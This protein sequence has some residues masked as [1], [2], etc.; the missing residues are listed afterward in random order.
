LAD[1]TQNV[2]VTAD[3]RD[4][5]RSIAQLSKKLGE[6]QNLTS[7]TGKS[8][9]TRN[10][11]EA[12]VP[13]RAL[14]ALERG[15]QT[16]ANRA[17]TTE[18]AFARL[19]EGVGTLEVTSQAV[20]GLNEVLKD[21]ASYTAQVAQSASGATRHIDQFTSS[22]SQLENILG[23][24]NNGLV[25]LGHSITRVVVPGFAVLDDAAQASAK[26]VNAAQ[27][28]VQQLVDSTEGI[29]TFVD[30][31]FTIS[32]ATG[33]ATAGI[34]ALAAVVEGQ[35]SN[36]LYDIDRSASGALG[37][38]ADDAAA[39]VSE[40][41]RLIG[42]GQGTVSQ[43]ENL[44]RLGKERQA[45]YKADSD[46]GRK[47]VN[48]IYRAQ[49]L[50]NEEL[51]RQNDLLRAAKGLQPQNVRDYEVG[52]RR[53][54]LQSRDFKETQ[55]AKQLEEEAALQANL[56]KI[57]G[58]E[59]SLLEEKLGVQRRI[60]NEVTLQAQKARDGK[61]DGS[62]RPIRPYRT[63]EG[64]RAMGFPIALPEIAQ[65]RK[66]AALKKERA[67]ATDSLAL[68]KSNSLLAS[69]V[70][71]LR[72]QLEI[73]KALGPAYEPF[74]NGLKKANDRQSLLFRAR[75][76]RATRTNLGDENVNRASAVDAI[77]NKTNRSVIAQNKLYDIGAAIKR[78]DFETAK[79]L[80]AE[81]DLL[82]KKEQNYNGVVQRRLAFRRKEKAEA[83]ELAVAQTKEKN[84]KAEDAEKQGRKRLEGVAIGGA[85]PLLFG[86]GAGAVLGGALGGLNTNNPIFSVVT[87]A[88]GTMADQF[89]AAAADMGNA[90]RDPI[91]NFQKIAD[92][93]LLANKQ[94]E[95]YVQRLIEVG[96]VTEASS[97]VQ[98]EII[99]KIGVSGTNS[100]QNAGAAAIRL[101]KVW[102]ELNLQLQAAVSG[103]LAALLSWV[104]QLVAVGNSFRRDQA[105][106]KDVSKGLN[107]KDRAEFEKTLARINGNTQKIGSGV[108]WEMAADQRKAVIAEYA[109]RANPQSVTGNS[110]DPKT[111]EDA[112]KAAQEQ[113]DLI[114]SAY[115]EAFD[116]QRRGID[117][118]REITDYRRKVE[119]D[120]FAKQQEAKRLEIDNAR[121]AA[122]IAIEQTDLAL[123]KQFSG[124]EGLTA[125]LLGGVQTYITAR[126]TGEADLE[127]KQRQLQVNLADISKATA[128]YAYE[129]ANRRTQLERSIEDYK[130]S[131]ADYQLKIARQIQEQTVVPEG[132]V[133]GGGGGANAPVGNLGNF[134]AL[135]Q[136]IGRQ[137]SYGGNYGAFNRGGSDGGHTAHDSGKDPNLVNMTIAEIQRRQLAPNVPANQQLHAVGKYQIIGDTLRGLLKG[138]YGATGISSSDKF[139]PEVQERLG[140]ALARNRMV[141]GNV[142]ASMRGLRQEW[143]GL[144][145][146]DSGKL[147]AAITQFQKATGTQ[148]GTAARSITAPTFRAPSADTSGFAAA[149]NSITKAKED[150]LK[151]D[152]EQTKLK[153][154]AA[155]FNIQELARGQSQV[156]QSQQ[157]LK[158]EKDKLGI[159]TTVGAMSENQLAQL[160]LRAE[161]ESKIDTI[162]NSQKNTLL[163][164]NAA[165]TSG[166]ITQA[167]AND[168]IKGINTG[169]E[170]RLETTRQQIVLEQ[171]L[172]KVQQAQQLA[173]EAQKMQT[174]LATAG[175]GIRAGFTGG[176]ASKY[177]DVIGKTGN[178][179]LANQFA[180]AQGVLDQLQTAQADASALG[181]SIA[182][183][184]K[185]AIK[186]SVTGGDIG[187]AFSSM[188][189]GLGD[190]FLEMA[191]R[192]IEQSLTQAIF[193]ML[194]PSNTQVQAA[195]QMMAAAQIQ[196]QAG[197]LMASGGAGGG[198]GAGIS[199][200][201][202]I[203]T[204]LLGGLFGGGGFS[205]G[206]AGSGVGGAIGSY[207][208][209][210]SATSF[211]PSFLAVG[212]PAQAGS[213]YIVGEKGPELFVPNAS[214]SVI[215]ADRTAAM[216]RYQRQSGNSGGQ[217]GESGQSS[218]LSPAGWQ[219]NFET[220]QILGQDWISKDQLVA[221]MAE[222][223]KR[224]TKAGAKAGASQMAQKMRSSPSFRKQVG[225]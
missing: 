200:F 106:A 69:D 123:R 129:Q 177:E 115:R 221:A 12:F 138:N 214:G 34:A 84:K 36:T 74:L 198:A 22:G 152:K 151:L 101:S 100:M 127:Q 48:T 55:A 181:G 147:R 136:L 107:S 203:A 117:L 57:Q 111:I 7:G 3:T 89:A 209:A 187:A 201:G 205:L 122:Q 189:G 204:S 130:R 159:I 172:L 153:K 10:I 137:E 23:T 190:K 223:E 16:I 132:T 54:A 113:A 79:A 44:L 86:G 157:Q 40:L 116:L 156:E 220:T 197:T 128:D 167:E 88:L 59:V 27:Y 161:G 73:I 143:I 35:L 150:E 94:Q 45:L 71:L 81:V 170:K 77:V 50:L 133:G 207:G 208:S 206:G 125:D 146:A 131:I 109:K 76:N 56:L 108:T 24:V 65:D 49:T 87:S 225:M 114:K 1:Y 8:A 25:D 6:L 182:G 175:K 26:T 168:L 222:T 46:E 119:S 173:L 75:E 148:L 212:G 199:G 62:S 60:T 185:E 154:D 91:T 47:A 28:A 165:V 13:Q 83:A 32:G 216:A 218:D 58:R 160:Q 215:P 2:K 178:S 105:N 4:A 134:A 140:A 124:S 15:L 95:Y 53:N 90:L 121:K 80:G 120:I 14:S 17:N 96:R 92:A 37:K 171:E 194:A 164:I 29:K 141:P 192:P 20:N 186:A 219:M 52:K 188:L 41:Q 139:S 191:F 78:N 102:A 217:G 30:S 11:A 142:D 179:D 110:T 93:G 162:V 85:F 72:A 21:A 63:V 135:S 31:F 180:K 112:R 33:A 70:S 66:L 155:I 184:F 196:L 43:Y 224:A 174:E 163:S 39:G 213:P 104:T 64:V 183:G 126:R 18:K 5:E 67:G 176:A 103:P 202:G 193:G 98:Q 38:L 61:L 211:L 169:V 144:Q 99:N 51:Q 42:A 149:Q 195:T 166:V 97:V 19:V 9:G 145:D 68:Q 158:L 118:Q 210:M 82:V